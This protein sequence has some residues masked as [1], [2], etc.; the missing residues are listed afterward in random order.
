LKNSGD[1]PLGQSQLRATLRF[2]DGTDRTV[3]APVPALEAGQATTLTVPAGTLH[4][5]GTVQYSVQWQVDTPAGMPVAAGRF[6]VHDPRIR[7]TAPSAMQGLPGEA[8]VYAAPPHMFWVRNDG[9]TSETVALAALAGQGQAEVLGAR[10]LQLEPGQAF[11]V[12]VR[13]FLPRAGAA[14]TVRLVASFGD[15]GSLQWS[16]S[17]LTRILDPAAPT[18][19]LLA[20]P[21]QWPLASNLTVEADIEDDGAVAFAALWVVS[22]DGANRTF[23][24]AQ[25]VA[26]PWTARVRFEIPGNHTLQATA[27]DT[28]GN[29][30]VTPP[31]RVLARAA[32]V[33]RFL[34]QVPEGGPAVGGSV[35]L[36]V[37]SSSAGLVAYS[38]RQGGL[39]L[40]AGHAPLLDGNATIPLAGAQA[41]AAELEVAVETD[42]G[43]ASAILA[44]ELVEPASPPPFSG[45]PPPPKRSPPAGLGVLLASTLAACG[46]AALRRRT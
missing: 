25:G 30:A 17:V 18:I 31:W 22:P 9:N 34:L 23:A 13:H 11:A 2:A 39:L 28:L 32:A 8:V 41:G 40:D 36:T 42:A 20:R 26:G 29:H 7:V 24:F 44:L 38:L 45:S 16:A 19:A 15:R 21:A 1:A 4:V 3:D 33:P 12:G 43:P 6:T 27:V 5:P 10:I 35:Q 37:R 14:D 46:A